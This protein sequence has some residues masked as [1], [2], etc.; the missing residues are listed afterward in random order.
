VEVRVIDL[1]AAFGFAAFFVG[2]LW[3]GRRRTHAVVDAFLL[4]SLAISFGVGLTQRDLWP[5]SSWPLVAGLVPDVVTQRR[6]VLVDSVGREHDA[7]YRA[8]HP[9]SAI[10]LSGWIDADFLDLDADRRREA[11][12]FLTNLVEEGRERTLRGDLD[13]FARRLGPVTAPFFLVSPSLWSD[14]AAVPTV[15]IIGIRVYHERWDPAEVYA[16]RDSIRRE[17]VFE[18][19]GVP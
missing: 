13:P 9:L 1:I 19:E 11:A 6:I 17:M 10:E 4:Y 15:P 16:G 18:S 14:P 8:W 12:D 3:A 7:D 5:F 2:A